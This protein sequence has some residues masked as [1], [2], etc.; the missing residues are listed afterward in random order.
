[1]CPRLPPLAS[2][3][4]EAHGRVGSIELLNCFWHSSSS[5]EAG[6]FWE[7]QAQA[8]WPKT[9]RV[10]VAMSVRIHEIKVRR[11]TGSTGPQEAF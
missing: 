10:R 4:F 3:P 7:Q 6:G 2:R 5:L 11:R 8:G 1:M 9:L